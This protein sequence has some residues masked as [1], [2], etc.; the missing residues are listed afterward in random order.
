MLGRTPGRGVRNRINSQPREAV[1][2][3]CRVRPAPLSAA[4]F[5]DCLTVKDERT[6]LLDR[7]GAMR[8]TEYTFTRVFDDASKQSEVF[9]SAGLPLVEELVQ[10]RNG[11]LFTYGVTGSGKSF[12]MQGHPDNPG[13]LPRCLDSLFNSV[14]SRLAK[15]F[16]I[17][18]DRCNGFDIHS[19]AEA[20]MERQR[21]ELERRHGGWRQLEAEAASR[22]RES[23]RVPLGELEGDAFGC[24]VFV[25]YVEIYNKLAYDL[26]EDFGV[27]G[28]VLRAEPTSR[29]LREDARRNM[30]VSG[31]LEVECRSG[32]EA[33]AVFLKGCARR[34]VAQTALNAESSRSHSVF[35]IRLVRGC[36]DCRLG[37][38]VPDKS[39]LHVSQLCLV[40]LAGSERSLRTGNAG[41]RLREASN[42]NNSLL[43][44]KRCIEALRENQRAVSAGGANAATKIVPYRESKMTQLFKNFFDGDGSVKMVLCVNRNAEEVEETANVLKF[45]EMA[46]EVQVVRS[47]V[48]QTPRWQAATPRPQ[49]PSAPP[50]SSESAE[51]GSGGR[52][53]QFDSILP[54]S[55]SAPDS[56][57]AAAGGSLRESQW[58]LW[59][60]RA[61]LFRAELD[62]VWDGGSGS[63]DLLEE[64]QRLQAAHRAEKARLEKRLRNAEMR[65][66]KDRA[67][68][69][70]GKKELLSRLEG[71]ENQL[72]RERADKERLR[73]QFKYRMDAVQKS[74]V[75]PRLRRSRSQEQLNADAAAA[76]TPGL[77]S[78]LRCR[79]SPGA[80]GQKA[81]PPQ[82]QELPPPP[83]NPR[84]RR[85]SRSAGQLVVDHHAKHETPSGTVLCTKVPGKRKSV[86]KLEVRD[87]RKA[88]DYV[89]THQTADGSGGLR[90]EV[91]KGSVTPTAG[92]GSAVRFNDVERL[93]QMSPTRVGISDGSWL[94]GGSGRK[95]KASGGGAAGPPRTQL[96]PLHL[97]ESPDDFNN[98]EDEDNSGASLMS[99]D[100]D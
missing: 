83:S 75:R 44:L 2:V 7:A 26:L 51:D 62:A 69:D 19:E 29:A 61:R 97:T 98:D 42:I 24:A 58:E 71:Q 56:A 32:D 73:D 70:T 49:V 8:S 22:I 5:E 23:A 90:T 33:F 95:R 63:G 41:S 16:V 9:S 34:Q 84:Y 65:L 81:P 6:L 45:A 3:F 53:W 10:G 48:P 79:F 87:I 38:M 11:L 35:T 55:P 59:E 82:P 54:V 46:S 96:R 76:P 1:E 40:D 99:T 93:E 80:S 47:K 89:L 91:Y 37:E 50:S 92:G 68:A 67:A 88:T 52:M 57:T 17:Q 94:T 20:M 85:R 77:V 21:V 28:Q 64:V 60:Q 100:E 18:P 12:T 31:A 86:T 39:L 78:R 30:Y 15:K 72:R 13:L 74:A 4:N 25:S 43:V 14:G 27:P 36:Y 66:C